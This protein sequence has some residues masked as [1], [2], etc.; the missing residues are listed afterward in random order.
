MALI[1]NS[2]SGQNGILNFLES[3]TILIVCL[4]ILEREQMEAASDLLK[5]MFWQFLQLGLERV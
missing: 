2:G 5:K 1:A 4:L 3:V